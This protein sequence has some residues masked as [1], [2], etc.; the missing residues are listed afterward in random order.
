LQEGG[1]VVCD[2]DLGRIAVEQPSIF[3]H[4][5]FEALDSEWVS[6]A[7][8]AD[9]GFHLVIPPVLSIVLS[10]AARRDAIPQIVNEL[11]AEWSDA[12]KSI[13]EL[14]DAVKKVPTLKEAAE[15]RQQLREAAAR[16][17]PRSSAS[18]SLGPPPLRF[19]WSIF[20]S[21]GA[22]LVSGSSKVAI[23]TGAINVAIQKAIDSGLFG[24]ILFG[25]GAFD[26]GRRIRTNLN[27]V[28]R[29]R[30]MLARLLNSAE[31]EQ[32][33]RELP[34]TKL[35]IGTQ[36]SRRQIEIKHSRLENLRS[37]QRSL[38]R[39]SPSNDRSRRKKHK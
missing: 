10:R 34:Q 16:L 5:F 3:P 38:T 20:S 33:S 23:A 17:S 8:D 21:V 25:S 28:E 2:G 22:G 7:K 35:D 31:I 24:D 6:Y 9:D 11:R 18:Q 36:L 30:D 12:G 13:W 4:D 32:L 37:Q 27:E 19:L 15:I 26:L 39:R 29:T 14:L 1:S